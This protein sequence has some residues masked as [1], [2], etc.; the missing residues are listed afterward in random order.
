MQWIR[1]RM[2]FSNAISIVAL[3]VALGG[4]SYAAMKVPKH[5]VGTRQLKNDAVTSSKVRDG[6]LLGRDFKAGELPRGLQGPQGLPGPAGPNGRDG[7]DGA[8]GP[9]GEAAAFA[10]L[11]AD[12]TLLPV[13]DP[14]RPAE[15]KVV[16]QTMISHTAGTGIYCFDLPFPPSS[17]M[18]SLDNAGTASAAGTAF[19]A[20]VAIE[21]GN[22]INPCTPA[23]VRVL[24]TKVSGTSTANAPELA[25]HGFIIWFEK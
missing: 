16:D 5:S 22:N 10:R 20:S 25:D 15:D 3:F 18:V 12:G 19:V 17:A 13:L 1:T 11:Q 9:P 7:T 14:N 24:T 2:T 4:A 6:S 8:Q 21:R 23:D